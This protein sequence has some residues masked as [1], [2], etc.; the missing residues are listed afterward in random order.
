MKGKSVTINLGGNDSYIRKSTFE[1]GQKIRLS[2]T[3]WGISRQRI[4]NKQMVY[5]LLKKEYCPC[6]QVISVNDDQLE[7][8]L[9]LKAH[10]F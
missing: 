4:Q 9:T 6:L 5:R 3:S 1:V 10:N 7:T 2:K 8:T